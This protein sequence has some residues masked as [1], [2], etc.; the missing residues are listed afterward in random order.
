MPGAP[1]W[2]SAP[3]PA[4]ETMTDTLV[5]QASTATDRAIVAGREALAGRRGAIRSILPFAGPAIIASVAYMAPGNFATNIQA[6]AKNGYNFP[7]VVLFPNAAAM[8]FHG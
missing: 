8:P 5:A 6:G 3:V 2:R 1:H 7:R 4:K